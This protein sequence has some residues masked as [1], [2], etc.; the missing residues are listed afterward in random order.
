MG[1]L[2]DEGE[3]FFFRANPR[4]SAVNFRIRFSAPATAVSDG[5]AYDGLARGEVERESD[6]EGRALAD[7]GV[8]TDDFSVGVV[9]GE[10]CL[11]LSL[12]IDERIHHVA[13][14]QVVDEGAHILLHTL[15]KTA[16]DQCQSSRDMLN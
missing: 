8:V 3:L 5:A 14:R 2:P 11:R 4:N 1:S 7:A 12:D 10:N 16:Y 9:G 13:F 15:D 6:G